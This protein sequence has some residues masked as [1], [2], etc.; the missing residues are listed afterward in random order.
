[1]NKFIDGL[2]YYVTIFGLLGLVMGVINSIKG[3]NDYAKTGFIFFG[4]AVF[5]VLVFMILLK[6]SQPMMNKKV[7]EQPPV[8]INQDKA[9]P[10]TILGMVILIE[11]PLRFDNDKHKLIQSICEQQIREFKRVISSNAQ[12]EVKIAGS[13]IDDDAYAYGVCR[14]AFDEVDSYAD[15][16]EFMQRVATGSFTSSDGNRGKHFAYLNR[17]L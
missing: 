11:R 15:N 9:G 13:S 12:V 1:M 2:Y 5:I 4:I 8:L 14:S 3:K 16:E 17:K 10:L 7:K 6:I